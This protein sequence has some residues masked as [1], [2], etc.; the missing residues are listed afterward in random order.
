MGLAYWTVG[1]LDSAGR[2]YTEALASLTAA[3]HISDVLGCSIALADI[4]ITRGR[5]GDAIRTYQAGLNLADAH[6]VV[7]GTADMHIGL[8]TVLLERND[9]SAAAQHLAASA[10][11]GEQ[12]GLP[13]NAYRGGA[14]AMAR[15]RRLPK[16]M[17]MPRSTLLEEAEHLYNTDMSPPVRP[18]AAVKAQAQLANGDTVS[19]LRWA[20]SAA[21][22]VDDDLTYVCE[23]KH[24]TLARVLLAIH[25]ADRDEHSAD[26]ATRLLERLL[27]AAEEGKRTGSAIEILIV[28][29]LAHQACGDHP[30]ATAADEALARAAP[31]GYHRIFVDELPT[32]APLLRATSPQGVAG[33]HARKLLVAAPAAAVEAGPPVGTNRQGLVDELSNRELDVLRLLRSDLSGPDIARELLVSL[34]TV[35]T[36]T[37]NIYMKLGVNNRREA[38]GRRRRTRPVARRSPSRAPG[39][40]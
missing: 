31:E 33:D 39:P 6:G 9:R 20:T 24:I 26:G 2:R 5:L 25:T 19:P 16:E 23:Y 27:A 8:S 13:Q 18:V 35:R 29:A 21:L 1:D 36:H 3:G 15:L 40:G 32:L 22:A 17:W 12:A 4:Q 30:A 7:R 38:V 11:L 10:E 14:L 28:L 34:N 37:K